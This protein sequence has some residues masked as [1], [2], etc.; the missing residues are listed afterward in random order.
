M[1]MAE[2]MFGDLVKVVVDVEHGLMV[3]DA[4]MHGDDEAFL[5]DEFIARPPPR[6][7]R[8]RMCHIW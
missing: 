5:L 4:E 6:H 1:E 3:V 2:R 7:G 8:L